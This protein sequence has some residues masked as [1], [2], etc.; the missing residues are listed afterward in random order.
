MKKITSGFLTLLLS[1]IFATAQISSINVGTTPNDKT[2]DPL[3]TAFQKINTNFNVVTNQISATS[4]AL[5]ASV[6]GVLTNPTF[7]GELTIVGAGATLQF[8]NYGPSSDIWN[9]DDVNVNHYISFSSTTGIGFGD[10]HGGDAATLTTNG[11]FTTTRFVGNGSSVTSLQATN[12]V[13]GT[14]TNLQFTF[15]NSRTN[16]LYFTNGVLMKVT[17]P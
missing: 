12:I 4:N 17:N 6:S 13:G 1:C 8:T 7:A 3:R 11:V 16:T 14:T 2:G 5:L 9:L 10:G 15:N